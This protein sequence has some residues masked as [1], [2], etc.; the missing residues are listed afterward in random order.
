MTRN[1]YVIGVFL[2]SLMGSFLAPSFVGAKKKGKVP[3]MEETTEQGRV[4]TLPEDVE[5]ALEEEFPGFQIPDELGFDEKMMSFY[6]RQLI[7]IH[8]GV[9][10]GDFNKDKKQDFAFFVIT[11][12]S[13]WGP[14]IE[15]V[16]LNGKKK[17][18]QFQAYRLGEIY[19]FKQDYL[20]FRDGKLY[21]GKFKKGGWYINWDKKEK[22][23]LIHKS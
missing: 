23:Y 7:G 10:W 15:L 5:D 12:E 16:I 13:P 8:P 19:G 6:H 1:K 4:L 9:T 3:T 14:L 22:K 17:R 18:G 2:F 21:K 20:R 11:G